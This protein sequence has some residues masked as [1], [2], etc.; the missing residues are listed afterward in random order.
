MKK[1]LKY[2]GIAILVGVLGMALLG[3]LMHEPRPEGQPGLRAERLADSVLSSLNFKAYEQLA[4][5]QWSYPPGHHYVWNKAQDS[6]NVQW[7]DMEV[8][9]S[10]E[11]LRGYAYRQGR[12]LDGNDLDEALWTAWKYFANDSFW[13][14]A[15]FKLRDP[16]TTRA[17]VE[18]DQG[19]GLM[20]TYSSGGVTPGDSYLWILDEV[21]FRPVAWRMWVSII[22]VGGLEFSWSNWQSYDGVWLATVHQGPLDLV[23]TVENL[24]VN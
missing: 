9:L 15:P 11:T 22:P 7:D 10:T 3:I 18:T 1:I 23:I 17:Y 5:L 16:G 4:I 14:V 12:A 8:M 24:A 20:V 6:V 19:P 13:L 2:L 21:T